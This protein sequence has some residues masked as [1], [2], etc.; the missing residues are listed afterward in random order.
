MEGKRTDSKLLLISL[1]LILIILL[2]LNY[3]LG[4]NRMDETWN[5]KKITTATDVMY[6]GEIV[7]DRET[8][9][10]LEK[11]INQYLD[12]YINTN[13]DEEKTMYDSYYKYLTENYKGYLS[14]KEYIEVAEKFLNKFYVNINDNYETMYTYQILKDI[15][16]FDN[17]IYLCVLQSNRNNEKGYIALQVN[18][19]QS[20]FKIVYIE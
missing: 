13:N 4:K 2:L 19:E 17:N 11:I 3:F 6:K 7:T 9:Y 16:S 18:K 20:L 15:Y 8:Y 1:V 14:K 5:Y 10:T 12:S